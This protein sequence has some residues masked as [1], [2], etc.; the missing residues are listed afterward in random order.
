[1]GAFM[2]AT[3]FLGWQNRVLYCGQNGLLAAQNSN[4]KIQRSI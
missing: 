1:M 3:L 4:F 2:V